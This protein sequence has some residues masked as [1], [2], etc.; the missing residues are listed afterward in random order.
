MLRTNEDAHNH[1]AM[2]SDSYTPVIIIGAP[3]SGTNMLRDLMCQLPHTA[4]WD[5]DEINYIWRFGNRS[6][7]SDALTPE[8]ATLPAQR[9]ITKTFDRLHASTKATRIIEKTCANSLRVPFV[10]TIFP[11]AMFISLIRDGRAVYRSAFKRWS[12]PLDLMYLARKA[13]YVPSTDLVYYA[14]RYFRNRLGKVADPDGKLATWGPRF[15]GMEAFQSAHSFESCVAQQWVECVRQ[16]Q[17]ALQQIPPCRRLSLSYEKIVANPVGELQRV[18]DFLQISV[19]EDLLNAASKMVRPPETARNA[20]LD[21]PE[22][23]LRIMQATL[24]QNGYLQG[25]RH[26]AA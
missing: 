8:H 4:S 22:G 7:P 21:I 3:R 15:D 12:A 5:C 19:T 16:S 9:F 26:V 6:H 10:N 2:N 25:E 20:T 17:T 23:V 11:R 14:Y 1:G 18:A 24:E 13:R